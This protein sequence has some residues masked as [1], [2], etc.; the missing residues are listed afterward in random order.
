MSTERATTLADEIYRAMQGMTWRAA[1]EL[2][3]T[4]SSDIRYIHDHEP[5]RVAH[6][7]DM[8]AMMRTV[9]AE[10][11]EEIAARREAY[12]ARWCDRC[13]HANPCAHAYGCMC[14]PHYSFTEQE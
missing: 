2:M 9:K 13:V 11:D 3:D 12:G 6:L 8:I 10:T 7:R 14:G 4:H 5:S 1:E